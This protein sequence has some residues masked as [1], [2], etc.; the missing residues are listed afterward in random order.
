MDYKTWKVLKSVIN[1]SGDDEELIEKAAAAQKEYAEVAD[2]CNTDGHYH[3]EDDGEYYR[4]VINPAPEPPTLEQ[5]VVAL[6]RKYQMNR[7]QREG[8]LAEGS[9]YSEYNKAK[10][11]E[12]EDL[13][14]ELRKL[15][16]GEE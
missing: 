12:I 10:A 13:A 8:I 2:W 7:W 6:E 1:Y 9:L 4:T 14:E 5:Q 15:T 16:L 3:I 11:Q